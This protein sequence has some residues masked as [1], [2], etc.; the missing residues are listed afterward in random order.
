[1]AL[2][3]PQK[4]AMLLMNLD[5]PTA[6]ELLGSAKPETITEIATEL[7]CLV[8]ADEGQ[9]TADNEL[10]QEILGVLMGSK[11]KSGGETFVKETLEILLGRE[12]SRDVLRQVNE[13]VQ[14]RDPFSQLRSANVPDIAA[15]LAGESPQVVSVVLS[16]L[17]AKRSAELL[18]M[19]DDQRRPATVLCMTTGQE[20]SAEAKLRVAMVVQSRLKERLAQ[21]PKA[22]AD[23]AAARQQQLRKV[24]VL[25]RSMDVEVR[26]SLTKSLA[27]QDK[28]AA[29]SVEELMVIWEDIPLVADRALQEALRSVDSRKLALALVDAEEKTTAKIRDNI[30]ERARA[31]LDE[32]T[33]LLSAPKQ[34]EIL[35]ARE[36]ILGALRQ[37]NA[38]GDLEFEEG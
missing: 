15:C 11:K 14:A 9:A 23:P 12:K 27:E 21:G 34:D 29:K 25:L 17:P 35:P 4:A 10:A 18:A 38:S 19:L 26:G 22:R 6:A 28:E 30:S 32:E 20:V 2:T 37:M 1:M 24:A 7:A 36:E 31:M 3:G 16:E 13:R 33:S 8:Q 5:P